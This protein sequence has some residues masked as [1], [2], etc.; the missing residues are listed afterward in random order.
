MF[1]LLNAKM[2]VAGIPKELGRYRSTIHRRIHHNH[3]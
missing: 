1:R 2:P 3:L